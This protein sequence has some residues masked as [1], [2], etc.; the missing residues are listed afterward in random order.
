MM[1]LVLLLFFPFILFASSIV[2]IKIDSAI[3]PA[4]AMY[5]KN[6]ISYAQQNNS[7]LII[8][9]LNTSGGLFDTTREMIQD[10]S[11]SK[12]PIVVYVSPKGSHAASAGTYILYASH[13]AAMSPGTNIGATTPVPLMSIPLEGDTEIASSLQKKILSDASAYIQSLAELRGRNVHWA[14][15]SV[16]DGSSITAT[17]ALDLGVIDMIAQDLDELIVKLD[18]YQ[19]RIDNENVITLDTNGIKVLFFEADFKTNILTILTNPNLVYIFILI[20]IYGIFFEL[21]NPG[22]LFPGTIGIISG[23]IALYALNI[24]PF[25]YAGLILMFLGIA[26]MVAEVFVVGFGILGIAGV[27]SFVFGSVLLFD[28]QTLGQDISLP[29]IIAL[30]LVS[31]VF[32]VYVVKLVITS[33]N[34]KAKTGLEEMIGI[35][36]EVVKKTTN[37]YL[38]HCHGETWEGMSIIPLELNQKVEVVSIDGLVLHLKPKE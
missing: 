21:L 37:G 33:K 18:K 13:I 9:E 15:K 35:E 30:S 32:F 31:L 24:I 22:S 29:L 25:N 2:H 4:S 14:I 17:Q 5:L 36:A 12:I 3:S 11:N 27:V 16:E 19:V 10:I 38:V 28:A 6:S 7:Q 8:L 34:T 1:R 26:F 20:A 23:V